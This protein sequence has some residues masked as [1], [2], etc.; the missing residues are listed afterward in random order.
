LFSARN[1]GSGVMN[2]ETPQSKQIETL[3]HTKMPG[4]S[5]FVR[6]LRWMFISAVNS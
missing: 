4:L 6:P 1:S 2:R 5:M 3:G